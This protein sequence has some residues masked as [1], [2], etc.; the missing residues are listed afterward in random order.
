MLRVY[1]ISIIIGILTS[2]C[3]SNLCYPPSYYDPQPGAPYTAEEAFVSASD[4]AQL[5][6]TLTLP[7]DVGS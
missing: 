5:A 7:S 1:I 6:G 2:G 3:A 4:G